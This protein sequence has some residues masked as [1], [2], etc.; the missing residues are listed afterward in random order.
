MGE[1]RTK[2]GLSVLSG[3]SGELVANLNSH[4]SNVRIGSHVL[5]LTRNDGTLTCYLCCPSVAYLDYARDE[6]RHF[7]ARPWLKTALGGLI[8]AAR[9]L[10]CASGLDR[11]IQPN[12]W[13]VS[14]NI[15]PDLRAAEIMALTAM[16]TEQWPDHAIV[17]RSVNTVNHAHLKAR[18]EAA[19]YMALASRQ[20]YLF[21]A[22]GAAPP[23][24]RDEKRD[25]KLLAQGDFIPT[26]QFS[27][28]DFERMA[29]LYQALYLDKYTSLNP[30]YTPLFLQRAHREGLLDLVGLRG[31]SGSLDGIIGLFQQGDTLTAPIVGYDT[32]LPVE[33]GLYRRLMAIALTRA[34]DGRL[35]YNMSGG[36]AA[37]KRNRGAVPALEYMMVYNRHLPPARRFAT[38]LIRGILD[39]VGVPLLQRFAL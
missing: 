21:D 4:L 22:R 2:D 33:V 17:W 5:P 37:F 23:V 16:L 11:Q 9:P 34:R 26:R 27:V 14:T 31:P 32:A 18:F 36:A 1:I 15:L 35:L 29:R 7:V 6:L 30:R 25:Q 38:G 8:G 20:I 12:N 3:A 19:G 28:E 39:G 10:L 24:H 13:L